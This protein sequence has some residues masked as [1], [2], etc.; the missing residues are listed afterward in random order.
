M[1][2]RFYALSEEDY[3]ALAESIHGKLLRPCYFNGTVEVANVN[4]DTLRLTATLLLYRH[5]A[6]DP[7]AYDAHDYIYD[8]VAVWWDFQCEDEDGVVENDFDFDRLCE[9][10]I[11]E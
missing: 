10:I 5:L 2:K 8:V 7:S 6:N 4:G 11:E 9:F 1:G 3:A